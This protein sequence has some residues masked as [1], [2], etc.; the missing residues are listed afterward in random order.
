MIEWKR[1]Y[2]YQCGKGSRVGRRAIDHERHIVRSILTLGLMT[3]FYLAAAL[4]RTPW[5]CET[6]H[7]RDYTCDPD[8]IHALLYGTAGAEVSGMSVQRRR[9]ARDGMINRAFGWLI[10][11]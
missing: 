11:E 9:P 1:C 6:C 4:F 8:E 7:Q 2:C 10:R 5:I 3:P